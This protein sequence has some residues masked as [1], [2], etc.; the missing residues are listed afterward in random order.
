MHQ[1]SA[2]RSTRRIISKNNCRHPSPGILL[3]KYREKNS[4]DPDSQ[5]L[6]VACRQLVYGKLTEAVFVQKPGVAHHMYGKP[7]KRPMDGKQ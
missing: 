4:Q 2:H 3:T 5:S 6:K 7:N 1:N